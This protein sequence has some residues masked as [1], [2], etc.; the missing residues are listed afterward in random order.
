MKKMT[1]LLLLM[2]TLA[3]LLIATSAHAGMTLDT[4]NSTISFI[5]IKKGTTGEVHTFTNISGTL[6]DDGKLSI[7]IALDSVHTGID[8]R[9]IR[10]REMLFNTVKFPDA[11]LTAQ[12]PGMVVDGE[13]K[14]IDMEA[15]LSLHGE[16]KT[17]KVNAMAAKVGDKLLVTS[18]M[19]VILDAADFGLVGQVEALRVIASLSSISTSVP[20]SFSL[21]FK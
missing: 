20:V 19:P 10:M 18:R 7:T 9:D 1:N 13:I 16:S 12:V 17:L 14:S 6:S 3:G 5:S 2:M 11:T 8:I 21:V 4:K 15:S